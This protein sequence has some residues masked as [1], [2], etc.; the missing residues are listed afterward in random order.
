M[1][2][3]LIY[4]YIYIYKQYNFETARRNTLKLKHFIS[5]EKTKYLSKFTRDQIY[6]IIPHETH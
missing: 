2:V 5:I 6:L 1:F 4:I 3:E